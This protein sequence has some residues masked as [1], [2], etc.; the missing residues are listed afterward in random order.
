MLPGILGTSWGH[1]GGG[2]LLAAYIERSVPPGGTLPS[3][4][5]R[6]PAR[7][8]GD[9]AGTREC[10]PA[11]KARFAAAQPRVR[12][13]TPGRSRYLSRLARLRWPSNSCD[14]ND[15]YVLQ[16]KR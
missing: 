8:A 4:R 15:L 14:R 5:Y 12:C 1:T 7:E 9:G 3:P 16:N 2:T 6:R 13:R 10:N 11:Q